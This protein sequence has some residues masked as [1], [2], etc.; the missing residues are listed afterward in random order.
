MADSN[1]KEEGDREEGLEINRPSHIVHD[2]C[3]LFYRILRCGRLRRYT[4]IV[5]LQIWQV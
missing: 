5:R 2:I 4:M 3:D 1:Q